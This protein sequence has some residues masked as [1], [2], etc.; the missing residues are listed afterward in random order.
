MINH[1]THMSY[2][3]GIAR[4]VALAFVAGAVGMASPGAATAA[5]TPMPCVGREP[6]CVASIQSAL[7]AAHDGDV[8]RIGNGV[9][10]GGI[11]ITKSVTLIGRGAQ[12]TI[13]RGGGPVITIGEF[14]GPDRLNVTISGVTV[15]GGLT[16]SSPLGPDNVFAFGGGIAINPTADFGLGADVT[17]NDSVITGNTAAPTATVPSGFAC[18]G[19]PCEFAIA[20]GGGIGSWGNV[21]LN[22]SK[23][24]DNVAG[25][26]GSL[27][28]GGGIGSQHGSVT[29]RNSRVS[30]NE[31]I[32]VAPHGLFAEGGG[33]FTEQGATVSVTDSEISGNTASLT[34]DL[35]FFVGDADGSTIDMAANGGGIHTSEGSTVTIRHSN[36]D[37]NVIHVDDPNGEPL[38]FDAAILP[39]AS[40][41]VVRDSSISANRVEMIVASSEHVGASGTAL[42]IQGT[43]T[44]SNTT[45]NDNTTFITAQTGPAAAAAAVYVCGSVCA[46]SASS[47]LVVIT[48]SEISRNTVTA[49]GPG[50]ATVLGAAI[51]ND[52]LLQVKGT[53]ITDNTA[54]GNG[55]SGFVQG[56]GIRN[57]AF[58]SDAAK[59]LTITGSTITGNT[60]IASPGVA[61]A[62]GGLYTEFPVRIR[63]SVIAR[64]TPD[65]CSGCT[66]PVPHQPHSYHRRDIP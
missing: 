10:D 11:T 29:L 58:L 31:A 23:V 35:P 6:G 53:R 55:T 15:T 60:L 37:R 59:V 16:A 20:M 34:N 17:V 45:I 7:D 39:A 1:R 5:A 12:R 27:A 48:D 18:P 63:G 40:T 22:N 21:T 62:G 65:D 57:A 30:D 32:V 54:V 46:G 9:F 49:T 56:G 41:L 13:I 43:T 4:V 25:G 50:E 64:N 52:D 3:L 24:T 8:I 66:T 38:G 28:W 26:I 47:P 61:A 33:I 36:L 51:L 14:L 2:H 44:V 19:K 42:D